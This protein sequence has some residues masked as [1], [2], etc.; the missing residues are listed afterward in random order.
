MTGFDG[1]AALPLLVLAGAAVLVMLAIA[2]KRSHVLAAGVTVIGLLVAVAASIWLGVDEPARV[3]TPLLTMDGFAVFGIGLVVLATLAVTLISYAYL[4]RYPGWRE[5]YYVLLLVATLGAAVLVASNHFAS[6]FLGLETL[7]VPLYAM[8]G[9]FPRRPTS[10][11][12]GLKYLVLAASAAAFLLFGMALVYA[13]LGSLQFDALAMAWAAN[14]AEQPALV[15]A[16]LALILVGIGFKLALVPFHMWT[17][18]VYQ[19]APAPV[20]AFVATVSKGAM[21][22]VLLRYFRAGELAVG[23]VLA[24][25]LG[26]L[27]VVSM[28]A[29]NLLAL[30]QQNVK[31]ILAYSSIAHLGYLL[32]AFQARGAVA[33]SAASFYLVAYFVTMLGAFAVV[34]L[35]STPGHEA[36]LLDDYRGL[37]WQRPLV[38]SAFTLM[39]LSLAGIPLTAGF[40][41]KLWVLSA[42]TS[43]GAWVPVI[44]LV[45]GSSI[46]LYYYLRI[47]AAMVESVPEA[48]AR[49]SPAAAAPSE[50]L[51]LGALSALLVWFGVYPNGVLRIVAS[52]MASLG[53]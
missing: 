15:L 5:E 7:S 23:Q 33:A 28:L 12:A 36:E 40:M 25:L 26:G 6:F 2:L 52:A 45:A 17:P 1:R 10:L 16:G 53:R 51:A 3:V 35:L 21:L 37:F 32:V 27:A 13:A 34:T 42:G 43:A 9:F 20:A 44:V 19:G 30:L 8:I 14:R 22:F 39:L 50:W 48:A 18:D 46:G 31:R 38:A 11:E 41:G 24:T 29:G 4:G 49:R 47:V